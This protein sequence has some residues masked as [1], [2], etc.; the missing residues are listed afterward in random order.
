MRTNKDRTQGVLLRGGIQPCC[1]CKMNAADVALLSDF[2]VK[3][4]YPFFF[5]SAPGPRPMHSGLTSDTESFELMD[6]SNLNYLV[7][8]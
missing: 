4:H 3:G 8:K 5:H 2:C 6:T 1:I 7:F